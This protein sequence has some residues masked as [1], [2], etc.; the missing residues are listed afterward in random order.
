LLRIGNTLQSECH[1][2]LHN[3]LVGYNGYHYLNSLLHYIFSQ[4]QIGRGILRFFWFARVTPRNQRRFTPRNKRKSPYQAKEGTVRKNQRRKDKGILG[5]EKTKITL[6]FCTPIPQP[7]HNNL[8]M[9][10]HFC[11]AR[12]AKT[13][14]LCK[15]KSTVCRTH[16]QSRAGEHKRWK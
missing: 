16:A 3:L 1:D 14:S 5:T 2:F 10:A 6:L 11:I 13:I 4:I 8:P 7:D 12:N 9:H 15:A